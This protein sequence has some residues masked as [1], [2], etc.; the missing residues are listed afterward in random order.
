MVNDPQ[1]I[2]DS[3]AGYSNLQL[4]SQITKKH[5]TKKNNTDANWDDEGEEQMDEEEFKADSPAVEQVS[6]YEFA[7]KEEKYESQHLHLLSPKLELQH[8]S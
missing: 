4:E 7:R 6:K 3:P 5:K 8:L 1:Y 2:Q